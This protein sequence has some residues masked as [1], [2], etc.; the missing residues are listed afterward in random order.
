MQNKNICIYIYIHGINIYVIIDCS[1]FSLILVYIDKVLSC[2]FTICQLSE[3]H[4]DLQSTLCAWVHDC[5]DCRQSRRPITECA[6][7]HPRDI[8]TLNHLILWNIQCQQRGSLFCCTKRKESSLWKWACMHV[9]VC[10]CIAVH[11]CMCVCWGYR[12]I[13]TFQ[14][15]FWDG[16]KISEVSKCNSVSISLETV[17]HK[18]ITASSFLSYSL[19]SAKSEADSN[20]FRHL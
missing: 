15:R 5:R 18:F 14:I 1:F 11:L 2:L 10:Q 19:W 16:T 4:S 17:S 12:C 7:L 3:V 20:T 8:I 9:C 6:M 13:W